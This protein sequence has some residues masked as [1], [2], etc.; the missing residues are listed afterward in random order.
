MVS[1]HRLK[2]ATKQLGRERERDREQKREKGERETGD[3][4]AIVTIWWV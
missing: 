1:L 3:V 4:V 2:A